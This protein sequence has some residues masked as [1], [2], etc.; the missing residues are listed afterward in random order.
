MSQSK[1]K[2]VPDAELVL[3]KAL[4]NIGIL[5]Q[6]RPVV[7]PPKGL[8]PPPPMDEPVDSLSPMDQRLLAFMGAPEE[9]PA[10]STPPLPPSDQELS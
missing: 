1:I 3:V 10:R 6:K 9:T 7:P 5:F 8:V 4:N 2:S